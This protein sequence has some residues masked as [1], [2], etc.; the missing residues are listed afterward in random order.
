M[1]QKYLILLLGFIVAFSLVG[2]S[3]SEKKEAKHEPI[4]LNEVT[5]IVWGYEKDVMYLKVLRS[6]FV[7]PLRVTEDTK[8]ET[9]A[10]IRDTVLLVYTGYLGYTLRLP[11]IFEVKDIRTYVDAGSKVVNLKELQKSGELITRP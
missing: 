3:Q 9:F 5:G 6:G 2:C 10:S 7:H 8:M 1:K 11:E 4:E